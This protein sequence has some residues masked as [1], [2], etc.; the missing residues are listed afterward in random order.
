MLL[1]AGTMASAQ[2]VAFVATLKGKTVS[3]FRL[4]DL[5]GRERP[6]RQF[7]GKVILLNFWS[8]T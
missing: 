5:S 7:R 4:R 6:F 1:V 2:P 8:P 3:D